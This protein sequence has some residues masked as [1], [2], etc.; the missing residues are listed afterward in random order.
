MEDEEK[1]DYITGYP[2]AI[3]FNSIEEMINQMKKN[4][5]KIKIGDAQGTGFFCKIPFPDQNNMLKVLI[6]NNH[7]IKKD[8]L[9]KKDQEIS[10]LIKEEKKIRKLNLNDRIK[11]TN[12]EKIYD[13]TII[14]IKEEDNINNFLELDDNVLNGYPN[15]ISYDCSKKIIE[16]MERNI[17]K[18]N[19]GEEQGTGFFCKIPFP[20][21][22][23]SYQ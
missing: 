1:E 11:Y 8:I 9:F 14:E 18:I 6:T 15:I 12:D 13:I 5:C 10:I 16:Q 23:K 20:S 3:P 21:Q 2:I 22:D 17:C 19:I 4:I 7:V